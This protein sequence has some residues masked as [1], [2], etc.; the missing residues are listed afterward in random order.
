MDSVNQGI[1]SL[2]KDTEK[3]GIQLQSSFRNM[4]VL[5]NDR[6]FLK[7]PHETFRLLKRLDDNGILSLDRSMVLLEILT[8]KCDEKNPFPSQKVLQEH[9]EVGSTSIKNAISDIV[10]SG[11]FKVE[12]G[13][14]GLDKR[15][16]TYNIQPF[17]DLLNCFV[18]DVRSGV[19]ICVKTLLKEVL[20][21][22]KPITLGVSSKG[23]ETDKDTLISTPYVTE[24]GNSKDGEIRKKLYC[25]NREVGNISAQINAM[26]ERLKSIET[27]D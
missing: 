12:K 17:L 16:N 2:L 11:L 4:G 13:L 22:R 15:K 25:I 23:F 8:Y 10:K 21:G 14:Y 9:F 26:N 27:R 18:E 1:L 24:I 19:G 20:E 6:N 7:L 3:E 5:T